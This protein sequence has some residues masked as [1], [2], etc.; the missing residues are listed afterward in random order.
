MA[1]YECPDGHTWKGRSSLSKNF[2]PQDLT[3]PQPD[4]RKRAKPKMKQGGGFKADN[5][6]AARAVARRHFNAVV[7]Q[8]GC[9]YSAYRPSGPPAEKPRREDHVCTYPIDAH[10][11]VEKS[12][13]ERNYIDL[14]EDDLLAI[15]FDPRLGA[16]LCRGGHENV[17]TLLIYWDEVSAACKQACQ[18]VDEKWL[19]V[20]TPSGVRRKSMYRELRRVCPVRPNSST[21][22]NQRERSLHG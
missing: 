14:P 10:H 9:F 4:C 18:E 3:C 22:T 20:P 8:H 1:N 17:K 13:I 11:I 6:T 19:D 16:P 12:F 7:L 15:L 21:P 5:E 2:T